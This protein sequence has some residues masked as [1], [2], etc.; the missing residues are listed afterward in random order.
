MKRSA[1]AILAGFCVAA[2]VVAAVLMLR[3]PAPFWFVPG[4]LLEGVLLGYW[5]DRW[6]WKIRRESL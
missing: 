5:L 6:L 4:I 3:S 2:I 1:C